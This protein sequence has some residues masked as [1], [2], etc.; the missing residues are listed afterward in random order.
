MNYSLNFE[1]IHCGFII[2]LTYLSEERLRIENSSSTKNYV[3]F[4]SFL[5]G[6]KYLFRLAENLFE[7]LIRLFRWRDTK[8]GS[9]LRLLES[10]TS[11]HEND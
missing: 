2:K 8:H 4:L 9:F 7:L 3:N 6:S 10:D 11:D 1:C 5:I